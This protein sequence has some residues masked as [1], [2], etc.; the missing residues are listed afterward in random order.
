MLHGILAFTSGKYSSL[1]P[2]Y[3]MKNLVIDNGCTDCL[4][5]T[6]TADLAHTQS[7]TRSLV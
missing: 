6:K 2:I 4:P 1:V 5:Q 3:T 7:F